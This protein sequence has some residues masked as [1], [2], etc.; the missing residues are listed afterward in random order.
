MPCLGSQPINRSINQSI[1]QWCPEILRKTP[2]IIVGDANSAHKKALQ[3]NRTEPSASTAFAY[4][5]IEVRHSN[6][7]VARLVVSTTLFQMC[8]CNCA[9]KTNM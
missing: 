5:W 8:S 4:S 3:P 2:A 7:R 6:T 9:H 1:L